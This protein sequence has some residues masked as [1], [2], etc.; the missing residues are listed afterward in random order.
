[1]RSFAINDA[2]NSPGQ[3]C[4]PNASGTQFAPSRQEARVHGAVT[5]ENMARDK[6]LTRRSNIY[7][8]TLRTP[9]LCLERSCSA[10]AARSGCGYS[11]LGGSASACELGVAGRVWSV[12]IPVELDFLGETTEIF[13]F[14]GVPVNESG[15][16]GDFDSGTLVY[17]YQR[18]LL[19]PRG[20][21]G[22]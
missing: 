6:N 1:M 2:V 22:R 7:E 18:R 20:A 4:G 12:E 16:A 14:R 9:G 15:T 8:H 13:V 17:L 19:V 21:G 3:P 10:C 11:A 5:R